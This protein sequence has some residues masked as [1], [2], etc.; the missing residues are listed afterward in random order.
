METKL[1][2]EDINDDLKDMI[3]NWMTLDDKIRELNEQLKE[4]KDEKKQYENYIIDNLQ[5]Y[6]NT[7]IITTKGNITKSTK[8]SK[9]SITPEIIQETLTTLLKDNHTASFYVS[10]IHE[11]RPIKQLI[12]LKIKKNS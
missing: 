1:Q 5:D 10:K 2:L 6:D 9:G 11:K 12:N 4:L 7:V 8:S 3:L